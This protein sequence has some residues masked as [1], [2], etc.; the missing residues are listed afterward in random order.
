MSHRFTSSGIP[1]TSS[2]D[3][4]PPIN[5]INDLSVIKDNVEGGMG[6]YI[7]EYA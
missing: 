3:R 6:W 5:C 4:E 1:I 7:F 2:P